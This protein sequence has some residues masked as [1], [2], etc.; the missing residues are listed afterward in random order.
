MTR[1]LT[2]L[3]L[4]LFS[5]LSAYAQSQEAPR[6]SSPW[7]LRAGAK[8][9]LFLSATPNL[10]VAYR[11]PDDH[12]EILV[13]GSSPLRLSYSS[14][15]IGGRYYFNPE[16]QDFNFFAVARVGAYVF[17][18]ASTIYYPNG[19]TDTVGG[20][21]YNPDIAAG[22]GVDWNWTPNVGL[23]G[24]LCGGLPIFFFSE[25]ALKYTF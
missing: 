22:L 24:S 19:S 12:W 23:T 14:L 4:F 17:D 6:E 8:T 18:S 7:T 1:K 21:Q 16:A 15:Q 20:L 5:P 9:S 10:E 11:L 2:L 25:I 3:L 13:H